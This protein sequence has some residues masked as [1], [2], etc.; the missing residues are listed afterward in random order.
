[1]L[2][3]LPCTRALKVSSARAWLL[4]STSSSPAMQALPV[5]MQTEPADGEKA[6]TSCRSSPA[7]LVQAII[8]LRSR[9][10]PARS[11]QERSAQLRCRNS[12]MRGF[13]CIRLAEAIENSQRPG[14]VAGGFGVT[15]ALRRA[16]R[17]LPEVAQGVWKVA[18]LLEMQRQQRRDFR[19]AAAIGFLQPLAQAPVG[20]RPLS[21]RELLID[22]VLIKDVTEGIASRIG[23]IRP[24]GYA[25]R[26]KRMILA[27]Q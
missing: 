26:H 18:A 16:L 11:P 9:T 8:S 24:F 1:M 17:R 13:N 14:Q 3:L 15:K 7:C 22:D 6:V 10:E 2:A 19:G 5:G 27:G 20:L 4:A 23:A 25:G 12:A 21:G